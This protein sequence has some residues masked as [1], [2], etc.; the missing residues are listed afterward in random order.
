M[1]KV[2]KTAW[3]L[4][5]VFCWHSQKPELGQYC[6]RSTHLN[7]AQVSFVDTIEARAEAEE[8]THSH[9]ILTLS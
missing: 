4:V 9:S 8:P 7:N 5:G 1:H 6:Q 2:C 3:L